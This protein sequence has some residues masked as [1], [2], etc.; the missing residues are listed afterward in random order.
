MPEDVNGIARPALAGQHDME[1]VGRAAELGEDGDQ[2]LVGQAVHGRHARVVNDQHVLDVGHAE[3][4]L[5]V[6]GAEEEVGLFV[7]GRGGGARGRCRARVLLRAAGIVE[8]AVS[9]TEAAEIGRGIE[10]NGLSHGC[11]G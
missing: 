5:R 6:V 9:I 7:V 2:D 3:R 11:W 8:V 1:D 10:G 4:R